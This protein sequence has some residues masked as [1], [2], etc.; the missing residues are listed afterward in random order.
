MIDVIE[1]FPE[2]ISGYFGVNKVFSFDE[3][4]YIFFQRNFGDG[5]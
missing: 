5:D 1:K 4:L 2:F 3:E